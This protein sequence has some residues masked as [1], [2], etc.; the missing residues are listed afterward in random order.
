M[1]VYQ[2]ILRPATLARD[3]GHLLTHEALRQRLIATD[4]QAVRAYAWSSPPLPIRF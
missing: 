4:L 1:I 3:L 2:P